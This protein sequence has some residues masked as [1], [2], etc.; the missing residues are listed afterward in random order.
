VI[1]RRQLGEQRLDRFVEG[2]AR[3]Q[4]MV[5]F[6]TLTVQAT[7]GARYSDEALEQ[8]RADAR[9]V[10]DAAKDFERGIRRLADE[11]QAQ[12]QELDA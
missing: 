6:A 3:L 7:P 11:W 8:M 12:R 2:H 4:A 10:L 1:S 9:D 5:L